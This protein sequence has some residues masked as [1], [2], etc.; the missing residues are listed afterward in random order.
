MADKWRRKKE[1]RHIRL[2]HSIMSSEAWVHLTGNSIKVLLALVARDDGTRNGDI[3]FS[4]REAAETANMSPHTAKRC[5]IELQDKGFIVCTEKGAFS[6]KVS[7]ASL[8][9]YTWAAWPEGKMGPTRDFEKWKHDEKSRGQFLHVTEA[10]SASNMETPVTTEAKIAPDELETPLVPANPQNAKT[11]THIIIPPIPEQGAG[12]RATG[13]AKFHVGPNLADLRDRLNN[14][15]NDHG[16]GEQS[17]LAKA[18]PIPASTLSKF[19]NG[20]G[21]SGRHAAALEAHLL[22]LCTMSSSIGWWQPDWTDPIANL[23]FAAIIAAG[24][25]HHRERKAA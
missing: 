21:L 10:V 12:N 2:Y 9:R 22:K 15:L 23:T 3:S 7:H 25:K 6:R 8:W 5:L 24:T 19:R 18:I 17:R 20:G 16:S 11:S 13:T 4:V 1:P 14:H